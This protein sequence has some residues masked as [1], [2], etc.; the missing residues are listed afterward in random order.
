MKDILA[1]KLIHGSNIKNCN[2]LILAKVREVVLECKVMGISHRKSEDEII[3]LVI[4]I[5]Q[6][7]D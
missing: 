5:L 6:N 7:E 3:S 2:R 1:K 4:R